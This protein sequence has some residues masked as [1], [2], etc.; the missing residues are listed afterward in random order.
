MVNKV[1]DKKIRIDELCSLLNGYATAY[2]NSDAPLVSD[3][4]YDALYDELCMLQEQTGYIPHNSP[5]RRVGAE[6]ISEFLPHT[7][8]ARLY[9]LG[10]VQSEEELRTWGRKLEAQYG[11]Q[12]YSLEYKF[13]GLTVNLTYDDGKLVQAATRGNGSVGESI[14]P[15]IMTIK[16]IPLTIPFKGKAEIQG[17]GYMRLSVLKRINDG[18]GEYLK[19]ARNAAAGALRN[20]DPAV[21]ARRHLDCACYN[22]GHIEGKAF[23]NHHEMMDFL[24]ENGLPVS[25]Y[26]KYFTDIEDI[27][28]EING[29]NRAELDILIDGMVI[30]ACDFAL[31]ERMGYTEKFPRWAVAY[32]FPAEET[33]T[34][35][36]EII[37][38]VGRTGKLT[39]LAQLE[40]VQLCGA[41]ISKATLNN[42][43]DIRRKRVNEG[44][45]VFLRRSNDVIPEILGSV[46]DEESRVQPPQNCPAC[47]ARVESR[48]AHLYC[49]NTISCKP[50]IVSIL[51]H[52]SSKNAMDIESL[53]TKTAEQLVEEKELQISGLPDL[54]TLTKEQLLKLDKFGDKKA[55]TLIDALERSKDCSLGAF[56]F[57]IGI[58]NIG[59]KTAREIAREFKSLEKVRSA[60]YD[61][62]LA[63]PD[64][65]EITAQ[66]IIDFFADKRISDSIDKML[67]LGVKPREEEETAQ[68]G[69]LSGMTVVV[70]GKLER[71][72]RDEAERLIEKHGGNAASSVSKKT[73]LV[74]AGEAAGSKLQKANQLGI[75]V[76]DEEEFFKML[77]IE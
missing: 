39:P 63:I 16:T 42:I 75:R 76:I 49:T 18:G 52:F 27:I 45:R 72:S 31:R 41:T 22:I 24:R 47:G 77:G 43:D 8:I 50:Q 65:G 46:T 3:S 7:H 21:T 29:I 28:S 66:S 23:A 37:W 74:L 68:N 9:S 73:A 64:I 69:V 38:Q 61:E 14:L 12:E 30:K 34:T 57:A 48:G 33:T 20:L 10:K 32:K 59:E 17:E 4:E 25:P 36:R 1:N 19:N 62:F 54:Y 51:K 44:A 2:Y 60:T 58:P 55:S 11:K 71:L 15:Q 26:V 35:V 67:S 56:L 53:S 6:P 13:D 70:T 5:T 40:P